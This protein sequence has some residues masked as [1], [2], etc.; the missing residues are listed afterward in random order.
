MTSTDIAHEIR[1]YVVAE[2]LAGEDT[3]DLTG[4]YDLIDSGV[5]D[6]LGLVRLLSHITQRYEVPLDSIEFAPDHF[7][8]LD[9]VVAVITT[10]STAAT[11]V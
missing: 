8:T 9:A 10:H 5:I 4:D 1:A 7:R 6:S 3:S 2:F 11:G